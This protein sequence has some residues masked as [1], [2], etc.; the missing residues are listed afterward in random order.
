MLLPML[1]FFQLNSYTKLSAAPLIILHTTP[2]LWTEVLNHRTQIL[3]QV[4]RLTQP[5]VP[6]IFFWT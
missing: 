6:F 3:F 5:C 4:C 1:A 2:Q